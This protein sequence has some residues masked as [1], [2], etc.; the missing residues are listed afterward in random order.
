MRTIQVG[1]TM[2]PPG[3]QQPPLVLAGVCFAAPSFIMFAV[4][5]RSVKINMLS[6]SLVG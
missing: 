2:S 1:I 3:Q 5:Q 6:G 4:L